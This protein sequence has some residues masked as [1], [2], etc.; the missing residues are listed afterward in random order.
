MFHSLTKRQRCAGKHMATHDMTHVTLSDHGR[1]AKP[2][3]TIGRPRRGKTVGHKRHFSGAA[4]TQ[5]DIAGHAIH[6]AFIGNKLAKGPV[7]GKRGTHKPWRPM[8]KPTHGIENVHELARP[9]FQSL[10]SLIIARFA[11]ANRND[12]PPLNAAT[13]KFNGA[14]QLRGHRNLLYQIA[15]KP[16]PTIQKFQRGINKVLFVLRPSPIRRQKRPFKVD[17]L[18]SGTTLRNSLGHLYTGGFHIHLG[19]GGKRCQPRG[20]PRLSKGVPHGKQLIDRTGQN[21][22]TRITVD[23]RVDKTRCHDG[24][25]QLK[26]YYAMRSCLC[27]IN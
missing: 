25:A 12:N 9:R 20:C 2:A 14:I 27:N 17:A 23:V 4:C 26:G 5:Q 16:L 7:A 6:M 8:M 24:V 15:R 21:I 1:V 3:Q 18:T 11:M 10:Q 22:N 13:D 19:S